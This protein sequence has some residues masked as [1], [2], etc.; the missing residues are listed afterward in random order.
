MGVL[1]DGQLSYGI[2]FDE[3]FEFPWSEFENI[4]EWWKLVRG[5]SIESIYDDQ[6]D[7]KPGLSFGSDEVARYYQELRAWEE[8]N[9]LPVEVVTHFSRDYP[10]HILAALS[11]SA[12]RGY[13]TAI[14]TEFITNTAEARQRLLAFLAEFDIDCGGREP[15]WLLTCYVG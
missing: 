1:I 12:R 9:P 10:M 15:E 5:L 14:D 11:E 2:A 4:A 3:G 13:P 7:F 6:G 8:A